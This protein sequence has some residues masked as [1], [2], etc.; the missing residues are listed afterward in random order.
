MAINAA[1]SEAEYLS[2]VFEG[3]DREYRHGEV[4]ERTIPTYLHGVIQG[5][6]YALFL[7]YRKS[8]NLVPSTEAR[9]RLADGLI[10]IPDVAV[11]QGMP[12]EACPNTPPFVAIEVLSPDD[13]VSDVMQKL[14][15]YRDFGVAHVWAVDPENRTLFVYDE[16]GWHQVRSFQIPEFAIHF[17]PDQIFD[18]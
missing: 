18:L 2:A 12:R 5:M 16:E 14:K 6:L 8:H 17:T 3:L 4:V 13:R 11:H 1:I 7:A 15:E 10:R 9:H